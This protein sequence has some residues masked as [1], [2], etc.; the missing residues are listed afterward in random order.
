MV[1]GALRRVPVRLVIGSRGHAEPFHQ[2]ARRVA[3][4][5]RRQQR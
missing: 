5:L 4:R 1:D 2:L 3:P